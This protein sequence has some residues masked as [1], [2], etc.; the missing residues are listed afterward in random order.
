[1]FVIAYVLICLA[2]VHFPIFLSANW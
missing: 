2:F 1:V